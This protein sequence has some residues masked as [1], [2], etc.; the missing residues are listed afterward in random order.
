LDPNIAEAFQYRGHAYRRKGDYDRAIPDY[1][2]AIR[3]NPKLAEAFYNR[4]TARFNQGHF[5]AAV[6]DLAA[7][8]RLSPEN[9]YSV[10]WLHLAQARAGLDAHQ[11]LARNAMRL[12]RREWPGPVVD[13]YLRETSPDG[14]LAAAA[15]GDGTKQR[16]Q[17]CEAYFYLAERHIISGRPSESRQWLEQAIATCPQS[18]DE[19][20]GAAAELTRLRRVP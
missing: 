13:L 3:L 11:A 2:E 9:H 5:G 19:Y 12:N 8:V 15:R 10:I 7:A 4:G 20:D 14:V 17:Q 16:G 6:P 1:D 18:F